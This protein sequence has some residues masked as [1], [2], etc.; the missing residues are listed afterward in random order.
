MKSYRLL[1]LGANI[2]SKNAEA[3]SEGGLLRRPAMLHDSDLLEILLEA[4]TKSKTKAFHRPQLLRFILD[5]KSLTTFECVLYMGAGTGKRLRDTIDLALKYEKDVDRINAL[6]ESALFYAVASGNSEFVQHLLSTKCISQLN[7]PSGQ[8]KLR[9]LELAV[10]TSAVNTERILLEAGANLSCISGKLNETCLHLCSRKSG[11]IEVATLLLQHLNRSATE[12]IKF[13]NKPRKDGRTAY[14]LAVIQ[15][16]FRLADWY[17]QKGADQEA[18]LFTITWNF[19]GISDPY[20][21]NTKFTDRK[22]STTAS[23]QKPQS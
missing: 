11:S 19:R 1:E 21:S 23:S 6:K 3:E 9:P 22:K 20:T 4:M 12:K 17:V 15:G 2:Y 14:H 7:Q 18:A 8:G 16:H 10:S 13:L 5:A